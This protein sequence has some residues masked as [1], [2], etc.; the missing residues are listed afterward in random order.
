MIEIHEQAPEGVVFKQRIKRSNIRLP[1][2][3]LQVGQCFM[4]PLDKFKY[5]TIKVYA[6]RNSVDGKVFSTRKGLEGTWVKREA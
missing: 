2:D 3:E 5:T 6:S 4:A 1:F